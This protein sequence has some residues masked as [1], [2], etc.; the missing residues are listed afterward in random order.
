MLNKVKSEKTLSFI[1]TQLHS[2]MYLC[3]FPGGEGHHRSA[4]RKP[5]RVFQAEGESHDHQCGQLAC[6]H[7]QDR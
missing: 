6:L 5:S 1:K 3:F 7:P 4:V 2:R